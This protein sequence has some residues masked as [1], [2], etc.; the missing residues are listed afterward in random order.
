[1]VVATIFPFADWAAQVGGD[2]VEV[3]T[4]LPVGS[5]PH[6][7]E[8]TPRD[9]RQMASA[10]LF[11]KGG[12]HLDDWGAR[13]ANNRSADD[14]AILSL[15]DVLAKNGKLPNLDASLSRTLN[16]S[17]PAD[18]HD[19]DHDD[20]G[21]NPHFWLDPQLAIESVKLIEGQLAELDPAGKALYEKNSAA[22]IGELKKLD[23]EMTATFSKLPHKNF[24]SFHNAYP[25]LAQRY[26][27]NV[28]AVIEEYPGRSPSERYIREITDKLKALHITTVFSEPQLNPNLA[29][30]IAGETGGTVSMLDP[31]GDSSYPD[32]NSYIK[33]MKFDM[34][35][36]KQA[37]EK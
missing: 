31:Y 1:M 35:Q 13:L 22:Y 25:Y 30:I 7:F 12:L 37:L 24:V 28:A 18:E 16:I 32:R 17:G 15:G 34:G 5:S 19:A 33:V 6:T 21:I 20:E 29:K 23:S 14:L 36:L 2:R 27:L 11:I 3:H 26:G 10:R 8:P 4:L 9:M